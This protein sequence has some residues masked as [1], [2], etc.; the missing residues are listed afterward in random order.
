MICIRLEMNRSDLNASFLFSPLRILT[1]HLLQHE[2]VNMCNCV[3]VCVCLHLCLSFLHNLT[4][5]TFL[6]QLQARTRS[7]PQSWNTHTVSV[8]HS[9]VEHLLVSPVGLQ[10]SIALVCLPPSLLPS[11][12]LSI[13]FFLARTLPVALFCLSAFTS[14]HLHLSLFFD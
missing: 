7:P 4:L 11:V 1:R 14:S 10:M 12:H 5:V 6:L 13:P 9:E 3:C 8:S 2:L